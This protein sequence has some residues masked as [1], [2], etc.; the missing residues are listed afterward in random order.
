[1][2]KLGISIT[3]FHSNCRFKS[4][5]KNRFPRTNNLPFQRISTCYL[6]KGWIIHVLTEKR[7]TILQQD[8]LELLEGNNSKLDDFFISC[9]LT[10]NFKSGRREKTKQTKQ[11][12]QKKNCLQQLLMS[13]FSHLIMNFLQKSHKR[14]YQWQKK[15][16]YLPWATSHVHTPTT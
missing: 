13:I 4:K 16:N 3:K 2:V 12:K 7:V 15:F 6:G 10:G 5:R 8:K 9:F 1:M 14:G 11:T